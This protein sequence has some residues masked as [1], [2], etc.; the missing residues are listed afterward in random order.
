MSRGMIGKSSATSLL[1]VGYSNNRPTVG[2]SNRKP[3]VGYSM[4]LG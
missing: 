4:S 1:I 3:T 2:Y